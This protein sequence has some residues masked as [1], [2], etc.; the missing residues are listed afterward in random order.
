[1][2][3]DRRTLTARVHMPIL[4]ILHR[5]HGF[6]QLLGKVSENLH[7]HIA[8][9]RRE[10]PMMTKEAELKCNPDPAQPVELADELHVVEA[11]AP[12]L[13]E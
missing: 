2:T 5:G 4:E 12:D 6:V 13:D 3:Q 9:A 1:M 11:Q 7:F 8:L 10:P